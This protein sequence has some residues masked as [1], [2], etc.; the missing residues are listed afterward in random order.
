[1]NVYNGCATAATALQLAA[2]AIRSGEYDI[3]VA[4]GM[5]KHDPGAFT[6]DPVDYGVPALVRRD[7]ASS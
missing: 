5:D 2:D 4:V 1:M 3:G 7:R 6:A